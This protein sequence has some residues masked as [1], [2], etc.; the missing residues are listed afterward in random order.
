MQRLKRF[1]M[2]TLVAIFLIGLLPSLGYSQIQLDD[3]LLVFYFPLNEG[4]GDIIKDL[5]PNQMEGRN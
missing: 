5:G 2:S 3:P 1:P 4:K